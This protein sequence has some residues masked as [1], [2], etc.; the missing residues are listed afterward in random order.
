VAGLAAGAVVLS[1]C[2]ERQEA[3]DTL[4]EAD[5]SPS[6]S[7]SELPPLGPPGH[8]VPAEARHKTPDGALAFAEYYMGLGTKIGEGSIPADA[9]IE[10]SDG[11]ELCQ[12]V[13]DSYKADQA[14]GYTY[15]NS[16]YTFDEYAAPTLSGDTAELG[17]VYTQGAY[18]V[19]DAEGSQVTERSADATGELQ[20]GMLLR[21]QEP[22]KS[23]TVTGLTIG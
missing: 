9:L 18:T 16:T 12:Q 17:F 4:P 14:A 20:S 1:G 7:E 19:V 8:P 3:N 10:L 13:A 5:A 6:A 11:C 15:Q 2:S 21:W 23:W 22:V